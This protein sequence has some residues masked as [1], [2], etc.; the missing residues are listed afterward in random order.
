MNMP[1][2]MDVLDRF[3]VC[4]DH[5]QIVPVKAL[6][7]K[8]AVAPG[9]V[10]RAVTEL[11]LDAV[12]PAKVEIALRSVAELESHR[13]EAL[14]QWDV[15]LQRSEYE[16]QLAQRRYEA[17]DPDNRL[18]AGELESRWEQTLQDHEQLKRKHQEFL[19]HQNAPL[20]ARDQRLVKELSGDLPAVWRAG[21]TTM[22]DRKTL[23]RFL[24]RR[25]HLDGVSETGKIRI[26]VEWHTGTHTSLVIDRREVGVWAPKTSRAVEQ[27]IQ[28]LLPEH[29]YDSLAR[30]LNEEGHLSAKGLPFNR[31]TVGY[32][33]R[34]RGWGRHEQKQ[35]PAKPR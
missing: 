5:H 23:L 21:T 17:A 16:V 27:R 15:E 12:H 35:K 28:E 19:V 11:F 8:P 10:D 9:D 20:S 3:A 34:S 33:A 30:I 13:E 6:L 32:I 4:L 22:E 26:D 31:S 18:V 7:D 24:I 2:F 14:R 1:R 29:D 25:V